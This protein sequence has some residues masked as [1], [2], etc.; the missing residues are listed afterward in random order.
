VQQGVIHQLTGQIAGAS[1]NC[2]EYQH[3]FLWEHGIMVDLNMLVQP[4][5]ALRVREGDDIN[6]R[7]EIAGKA[8]LPNGDVHAVLLIP[9]GD[10][11]D[12]LEAKIAASQEAATTTPR[13]N[14]TIGTPASSSEAAGTPANSRRNRFGERYNP[15]GRPSN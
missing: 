6:D 15:P 5:S 13:A 3:A 12:E 11:D 8:V 4:R 9:D 10:C 1:T 2:T 7:G 14:P